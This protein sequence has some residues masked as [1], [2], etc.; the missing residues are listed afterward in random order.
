MWVDVGVAP[1]EDFEALFDLADDFSTFSLTNV[2]KLCQIGVS[3]TRF[4][5]KSAAC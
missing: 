1:G 5:V 2:H 4:R 3:K